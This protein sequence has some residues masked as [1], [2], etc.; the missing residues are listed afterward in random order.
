MCGVSM[1]AI[2]LGRLFLYTLLIVDN[3]SKR[4]ISDIINHWYGFFFRLRGWEDIVIAYILICV[5]TIK[6]ILII[7]VFTRLNRIRAAMHL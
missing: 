6:V 5:I 1:G 7:V 4:L 3:C 2:F